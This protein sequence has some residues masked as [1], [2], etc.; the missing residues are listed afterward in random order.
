MILL[1]TSAWLEILDKGPRQVSFRERLEAADR[2]LVPTLVVYEVCKFSLR[3]RNEATADAARGRLKKHE[4]V[5]LPEAVAADA[6]ANS[7]KYGLAMADAIIYTL[8]QAYGAT[9]V[10]G[11]SHFAGLDGVEYLAP[12]DAESAQDGSPHPS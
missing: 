5:E 4:I 3:R 12:S 8:A 9:L 11:D 1:D 2:V 6:A 10:T 7:L